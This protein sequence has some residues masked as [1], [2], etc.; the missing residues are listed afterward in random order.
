MALYFHD[1]LGRLA[2]VAGCETSCSA[3]VPRSSGRTTAAPTP[4]GGT[5]CRRDDGARDRANRTD[6]GLGGNRAARTGNEASLPARWAFINRAKAPG[7]PA[8]TA[9]AAS[10]SGSRCRPTRASCRPT[11]AA[12]RATRPSASPTGCP[13]TTANG[14]TGPSARAAIAVER[15]RRRARRAA[16][17]RVATRDGRARIGTTLSGISEGRRARLAVTWREDVGH[18][19]TSLSIK[20]SACY[21]CRRL[22]D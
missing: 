3:A 2:A 6:Q 18:G 21:V 10:T 17:G 14:Q 9:G 13:R 8:C 19:L 15:Q 12:C 1:E 11:R 5:R 4:A 22:L 20:S 16:R 7:T